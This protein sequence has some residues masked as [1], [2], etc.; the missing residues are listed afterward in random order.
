MECKKISVAKQ[1]A[2]VTHCRASLVGLW[3]L[4][5]LSHMEQLERPRKLSLKMGSF[6]SLGILMLAHCPG[7]GKLSRGFRSRGEG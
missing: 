7:W 3:V 5:T 4:E 1:I 2:I 6:R